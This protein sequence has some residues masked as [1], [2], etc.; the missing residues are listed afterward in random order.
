MKRGV[1]FHF[2]AGIGFLLGGASCSDFFDVD[3]GDKVP[4][5]EA[6]ENFNDVNAVSNGIYA[7]IAS[8]VHKLFLWGSARADFVLEGDGR[9]AFVSEFVRN[10]VSTDNPYTNYG[11]LYK[12]IARCN[13]QLA[14]LPRMKPD[15]DMLRNEDWYIFYGEAYF[16]RAWCYFMLVRTFGEVPLIVEE[17]SDRVLYVDEKGNEIRNSTIKMTDEEL[18][19]V[20]LKPK[21]ERVIWM[22]IVSDLTKSMDFFYTFS[23]FYPGW[24]DHADGN[25]PWWN[26]R[27][28]L[29]SAYILAADVSLWLNEY[30]RASAFA[31]YI[32]NKNLIGNSSTWYQQYL[33]LN[34]AAAASAYNS[35]GMLYNYSGGILNTQRMQEFTSPVEKDGGHYLV[36]PAVA[37]LSALFDDEDD[38]RKAATYKRMGRYDVI[39]K[40]IGLDLDGKSMR[41]PYRSDAFFYLIKNM[42]AYSIKG[43]A[44]CRR[45]NSEAAF[46]ML[47]KI[48]HARGMWEYQ[49]GEINMDVE[50]LERLLF[51]ER[52]REMAF[53]GKRWYDLLLRETV[54]GENGVIAET[55]SA[56]FTGQEQEK[57]KE[58]LSDKKNWYLPIEPER[59]K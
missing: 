25:Y 41:E 26:L 33:S 54:F 30:D 12:A 24:G 13:H 36:K 40:Y 20:A 29:R 45:G 49:K 16:V 37:T 47:N 51:L 38:V 43:I 34:N 9:D 57:V 50:N 11:F 27:G 8:D 22:Q 31:D 39:W 55:V 21:S 59:W 15:G 5:E 6:Y 42:E 58:R 52:A 19:A 2:V 28:T 3:L 53:E 14:N 17:V 32:V 46:R 35:F 18:R 48:R 44:E 1:I 10:N 23:R 56:K 7:A 4:T